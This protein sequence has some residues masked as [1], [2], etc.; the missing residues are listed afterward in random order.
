MQ[1][2]YDGGG[3]QILGLRIKRGD[4]D[5]VGGLIDQNDNG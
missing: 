1:Q 2:S 3:C 4:E 5:Y